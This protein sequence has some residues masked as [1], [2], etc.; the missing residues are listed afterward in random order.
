MAPGEVT[1]ADRAVRPSYRLHYFHLAGL[2]EPVR[3]LMHYGNIPFEDIRIGAKEWPEHK[4][5]KT[6][7]LACV[8]QG[9]SNRK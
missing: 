9:E 7:L 1:A 4:K 5:S 8:C 6:S 2:G 3:Y